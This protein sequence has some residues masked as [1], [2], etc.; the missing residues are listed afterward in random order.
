MC[1]HHYTHVGA[2]CFWLSNM[3]RCILKATRSVTAKTFLQTVCIIKFFQKKFV[4]PI[5]SQ[6]NLP[7]TVCTRAFFAAD[8]K[9]PIYCLARQ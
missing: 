7:K 5:T 8:W 9:F 2:S 6:K 4:L 1:S 3:G